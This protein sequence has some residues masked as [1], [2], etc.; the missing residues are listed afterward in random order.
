MKLA[1]L[2]HLTDFSA[3]ALN[4][5]H[6]AQWLA[7]LADAKLRVAHHYEL[8]LMPQY[9]MGQLPAPLDPRFLDELRGQ[10]AQELMQTLDKAGLT[11]AAVDTELV[12]DRP[13][14]AVDDPET[15]QPRP[16]LVVMGTTGHTGALHGGLMGTTTAKT[17][18]NC[19]VSV[20]G[21]S[22]KKPFRACKRILYLTDFSDPTEA[23]TRT[24]LGFAEQLGAE[25]VAASIGTP[26]DFWTTPALAA[27]LAKW[28]S[29]FPGYPLPHQFIT[30][31]NFET[32][33]AYAVDA[34]APDLVALHTTGR[35]PFWHVFQ[36]A[37]RSASL[38]A[39]LNKPLL[40]LKGL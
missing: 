11:A 36:E 3:A 13:V 28:R 38:S 35:N 30:A 1:H 15:N 34:L 4:A 16:D 27:E 18:R 25:L 2:L 24:L 19:P 5:L 9:A 6:T 7:E 12:L 32:G 23:C 39:H 26:I 14:W 10:L 17:I 8:P 33:V 22:A 29:A 40:V 20:V 21:V 31:R 37:S